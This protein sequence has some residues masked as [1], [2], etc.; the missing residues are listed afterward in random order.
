MFTG[1]K[2][3]LSENAKL[4]CKREV[5]DLLEKSRD[6]LIDAAAFRGDSLSNLLLSIRDVHLQ[7]RKNYAELIEGVGKNLYP[8]IVATDSDTPELSGVGGVY[9]LY[10]RDGNMK[11]QNGQND[12]KKLI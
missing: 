9:K 10:R 2:K 12:K 6:G 3:K 7:T 4:S 5:L 8:L 1:L 11:V